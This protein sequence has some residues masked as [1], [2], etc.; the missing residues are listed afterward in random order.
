[1]LKYFI[2]ML[3]IIILYTYIN[4]D[5]FTNT[6]NI[7]YYV[8]H[9]KNNISKKENIMIN[10]TKLNHQINIFDA[11]VGKNV[12]LNYLQIFDSNLVNNFKYTYIGEVGCYL[13]HMMLVK[14]LINKKDGYTVIFEDDFKII[15]DNLQDDIQN[16]LTLLNDNFDILYLGN[17]NNN[18]GKQYKDN[19]YYIDKVT[20]L[21]GLHAY[22]I[23]NKNA[24][25]IFN[26]LLN[27]NLEIDNKY[28]ILFDNNELNGFVLYPNLVTQ[29]ITLD[30]DIKPKFD[31]YVSKSY[32]YM[33]N[34]L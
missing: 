21:W 3:L 27:M 18:H 8:I 15:S 29:Q 32:I 10:Q 2:I 25:K 1:M 22:V 12:D 30:S 24:Q 23:N 19:I 5:S 4:I 31:Y 16:A 7:D 9:M 11:I 17:L 34:L 33:S 20:P 26:K 13:S 28:K 14:S 6:F